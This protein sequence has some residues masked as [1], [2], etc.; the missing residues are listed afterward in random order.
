MEELKEL[1]NDELLSYE[2]LEQKLNEKGIKLANIKN[3]GYINKEKFD[4]QLNNYNEL[5]SLYDKLIEETKDFK[6]I[7]E[8]LSKLKAE[9][10]DL[11]MLNLIENKNVDKK[12]AKFI[13]NEIKGNLAENE[14]FEDKL[15]EYLKDNQQFLNNNKG[16]ILSSATLNMEDNSQ[17]AKTED[18]KMNNIFRNFKG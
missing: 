14:K 1:F 18:E 7:T 17:V 12:F 10:N 11:T 8:E 16:M 3:G 9:K 5:K 2:Q 6:N 13:L 4:K 15:T